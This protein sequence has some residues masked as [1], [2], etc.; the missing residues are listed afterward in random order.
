[1]RQDKMRPDNFITKSEVG[2]ETSGMTKKK[3]DFK[4]VKKRVVE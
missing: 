3:I 1:M 2:G 4:R